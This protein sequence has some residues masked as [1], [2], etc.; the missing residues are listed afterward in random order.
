MTYQLRSQTIEVGGETLTVFEAS[1]LMQIRRDLMITAANAKWKASQ[2]TGDEN[3]AEWYLETLLYPSLVA[4]TQGNVPSLDE[5]VNHIPAVQT[6]VWEAAVRE[7][8][9]RWFPQPNEPT[10]EA[11]AA[12]IEKK[13]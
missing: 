10:P 8:N 2:E 6:D 7:L 9:P 3:Q 1:N 4:C 5:F 11:E 13:E 12:A